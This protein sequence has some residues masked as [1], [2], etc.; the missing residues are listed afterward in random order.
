MRAIPET[1]VCRILMFMWAFGP[2]E[3]LLRSHDDG[4]EEQL[5]SSKCPLQTSL[6][7]ISPEL[8]RDLN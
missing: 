7:P 2:Q 4:F 1:L 5:H 3:E 6:S 8:P